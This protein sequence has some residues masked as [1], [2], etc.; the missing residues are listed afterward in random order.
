MRFFLSP[1]ASVCVF[2][3]S[4]ISMMDRPS[5][6]L[7]CSVSAELI[8][9]YVASAAPTRA[10]AAAEDFEGIQFLNAKC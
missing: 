2:L 10:A 6:D 5:T 8:R 7:F 4:Q 1:N 9:L 3:F